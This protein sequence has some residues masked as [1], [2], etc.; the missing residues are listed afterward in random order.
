[1]KKI[2]TFWAFLAV[3][4]LPVYGYCQSKGGDDAIV[5]GNDVA[6]TNTDNGQVAGYIHKGIYTYK[7]IPYATA[8]R[9]MAPQKPAPWKG[10]RSSRAYGPVCPTDVTT[11]VNDPSEFAYHHDWGYSSE[12]C[13]VLNVW[14]KGLNDGKKRPVM[15]WIH[16]GGFTAGSS[17]E[18]PSYDGENLTRKG[19]VVVVS[20]NHRLNV[21]GFLDM[22]AYG[23]KYKSSPNA[24]MLDIVAALQWVKQN[25]AQF[26]GDPDNVTIFGQSGGGGKVSTLMAAPSAKG[27]F[28]KAIVQSGSY[29]NNFLDNAIAKRV[30]AALLEELNLQPAQA[31]S[32]KTVP[33]DRLYAASKKA[34]KKV[35]DALKA[36][37]KNL[38]G[39]GLGWGPILDNNFL[40]Y[41]PGDAA[42]LALSKDVP[43]LVGSTKNEIFASAMN[44]ALKEYSMDSIKT[45]L[46]KTYGD[47]TDAYMAEV[48]KTYPN[49]TLKPTDYVDIDLRFRPGVIKQANAKSASAA[50]PVYTYLFTWQSPVLDGTLK[51]IHCM[52]LAFQFNN[53]DRCEEMTGGGKAAYTLANRISQAWINFATKGDPNNKDL[54][55]WPKYTEAN[56][57][58]MIFD[59]QCEVK[60]NPDKNLLQIV[61]AK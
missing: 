9:F 44:P 31:D 50:A 5:A 60:S 26:G 2:S 32:L 1:M 18:L 42:A 61:A 47:K 37:G 28:Q 7:G 15:F 51:A 45:Y 16:G 39:F 19:D 43:L 21:L 24:G 27:L 36:E 25:I 57:A 14:T 13:Q 8:E 40:P 30:S 41:Q 29:V 46:Q 33:Y 10:I 23:D 38:P 58:T 55:T 6:V 11:Q 59:N 56:G 52:D 17:V 4:M 54:P 12:K 35:S 20:I 53:I 3:C 48:K 49:S 34:I 22:S